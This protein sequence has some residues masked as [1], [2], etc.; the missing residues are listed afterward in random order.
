MRG[1]V[2]AIPFSIFPLILQLWGCRGNPYG[3]D[4]TLHLVWRGKSLLILPQ[5]FWKAGSTDGPPTWTL[6]LGT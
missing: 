1:L 2:N 3:S 4:T 6:P 5:I